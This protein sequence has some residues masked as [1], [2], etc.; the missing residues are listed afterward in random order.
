VRRQRPRHHRHRQRRLRPA[1]PMLHRKLQPQKLGPPRHPGTLRQRSRCSRRPL[2]QHPRC[3]PRP[4]SLSARCQPSHSRPRCQTGLPRCQLGRAPAG[5][6]AHWRS[7][8]RWQI[9]PTN[10]PTRFCHGQRSEKENSWAV[11]EGAHH[12]SGWWQHVRKSVIRT[13]AK[14]PSVSGL[15]AISSD[16]EDL[17]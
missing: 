12:P 13:A 14:R 3:H 9:A 2:R 7:S 11:S 4:M 15:D 16:V 8:T 10:R 17:S 5:H 1:R 6:P